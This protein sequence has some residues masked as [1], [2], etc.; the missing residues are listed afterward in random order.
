MKD[1]RE[2]VELQLARQAVRDSITGDVVSW[3][4]AGRKVA[5]WKTQLK[6]WE[7]Q[8]ELMDAFAQGRV[9]I[10]TMS[11]GSYSGSDERKKLESI[12][13][14]GSYGYESSKTA[15]RDGPGGVWKSAPAGKTTVPIDASAAGL[16]QRLDP[17]KFL[18]TGP[19]GRSHK[20]SL[21]LHSLSASLLNPDFPMTLKF[22]SGTTLMA[23]MPLPLPK[24]VELF[25]ELRQVSKSGKCDQSFIS[26]VVILASEF[27]RPQLASNLDMGTVYAPTTPKPEAKQ[28]SYRYVKGDKGTST[29][30]PEQCR[31][32]A[33]KDYLQ[34]LRKGSL[35]TRDTSPYKGKANAA[36]EITIAYR[37]WGTQDKFPVFCIARAGSD[38][39]EEVTLGPSQT[40]LT[41][42]LTGKK[43]SKA[44]L[45]IVLV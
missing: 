37:K 43:Y 16:K 20:N 8:D 25:Y 6:L 5:L 13:N 44:A 19:N 10:R 21:A 27:T 36:N 29:E 39:L 12:V 32:N 17:E 41:Y 4:A 35:I 33:V 42:Q 24:D 40:L 45:K 23:L 14:A 2:P 11:H 3:E 18:R 38:E 15:I 31:N 34:I 7:D 1:L 9:T 28:P 26:Q 30:T 22:Y